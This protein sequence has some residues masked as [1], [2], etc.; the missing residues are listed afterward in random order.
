[1]WSTNQAETGTL[2]P[3]VQVASLLSFAFIRGRFGLKRLENSR[4]KACT[5]FLRP[6]TFNSERSLGVSCGSPACGHQGAPPEVVDVLAA[7]QPPERGCLGTPTAAAW[8]LL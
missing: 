2:P 1:M 6:L 5:G 4:S 7:E 8:S 3:L